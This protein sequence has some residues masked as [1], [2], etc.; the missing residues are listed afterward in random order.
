[1]TNW[2][3]EELSRIGRAAEL[4]VASRRPDGSV[5]PYVTIWAAR[6]GDGIY[7]RSAHGAGN[8]WFRRAR[9]AGRGRISAG[10][11]EADVVF[12]T[13]E[14]DVHPAIDAAL[15]AKYDRYGPGPVGAITGP[16][17]H[18]VTLRVVPDRAGD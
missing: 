6:C 8:P 18:P 7:I 4:R 1:M 11:V 10:G 2:T 17:A 5:R 14:D 9:E 13:P 16:S 3:S 12:E 15:H